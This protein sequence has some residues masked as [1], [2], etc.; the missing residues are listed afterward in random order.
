MNIPKCDRCRVP[1]VSH[2]WCEKCGEPICDGATK[3]N[4]ENGCEWCAKGLT[5]LAYKKHDASA[6]GLPTW[7][8]CTAKD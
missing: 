1:L 7:L 2:D 6:S 4:H 5:L 3:H 8:E